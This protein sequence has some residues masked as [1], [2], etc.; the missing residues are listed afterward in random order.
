MRE[1]WVSGARGCTK[2]DSFDCM[3][4]KGDNI[5]AMICFDLKS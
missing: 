5:G 3:V 2:F 4:E 1:F